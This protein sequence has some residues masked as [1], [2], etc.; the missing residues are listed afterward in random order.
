MKNHEI[1]VPVLILG[2]QTDHLTELE[3]RNNNCD[4]TPCCFETT[5]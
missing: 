1:N 4:G 3:G 2:L 5:S